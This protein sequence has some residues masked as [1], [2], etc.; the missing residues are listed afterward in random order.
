MSQ[1][2]GA[3]ARRIKTMTFGALHAT[4]VGNR[5]AD[6]AWRARRL[7]IL[8]YHGVSM[9]DEQLWDPELY[10]SKEFLRRRFEILRDGGYTVLAL[11][12]ALERMHRQ[13]LPRKS[14]ALTFD[15]GFFNFLVAAVPILKE[16]GFPATNYVSTYFCEHQQPI[17][18]LTLRYLLWSCRS[19]TLAPNTVPCQPEIVDLTAAINREKLARNLVSHVEAQKDRKARFSALEELSQQLRADWQSILDTRIFHLMTPGEIGET[20]SRGFDIQL[21]THRHR[22]PRIE[23]DFRSEIETNRQILEPITRQPAV[24]FCYPSGDVDPKFLPWLQSMGVTSATTG[25]AGLASATENVLLLPRYVDTMLQSELMFESRIS[26][27]QTEL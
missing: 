13:E 23:A 18:G 27:L 5:I 11:G 7:A 15:D 2:V 9:A 14:V 19:R 25:V 26:G 10:V 22:T 6:S 20:A 1:F 8:C 21:H 24:H 16:F 17:P 4:G 3:V 12:D